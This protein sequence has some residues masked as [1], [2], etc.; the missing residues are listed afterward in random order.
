MHFGDSF[1]VENQLP[2]KFEFHLISGT[3]TSIAFKDVELT[4]IPNCGVTTE[5]Q[6][7]IFILKP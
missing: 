2:E 3:A 6:L 1:D 4:L 7:P 5:E